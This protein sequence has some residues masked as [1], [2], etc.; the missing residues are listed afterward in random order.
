MI[1]VI[2][3]LATISIVAYNGIQNRGRVAVM[4]TDLSTLEKQLMLYQVENGTAPVSVEVMQT[5]SF[6]IVGKMPSEDEALSKGKYGVTMMSTP[7]AGVLIT[8][9][10]YEAG[11]WSIRRFYYQGETG[12][13][14]ST[15]SPAPNCSEEFFHDCN[16][17]SLLD[18]INVSS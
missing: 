6:G 4:K 13:Q 7:G 18:R 10:D 5:G 15:W 3:I 2:G 11:E 1:I 16:T 14:I 12:W 17:I 9:F 8:Y